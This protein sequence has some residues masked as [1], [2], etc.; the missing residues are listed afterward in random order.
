MS[1]EQAID[2]TRGLCGAPDVPNNTPRSVVEKNPAHCR[3]CG[4][5]MYIEECKSLGMQQLDMYVL[6]CPNC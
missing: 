4:S 6:I 2:H 5:E 3:C 1:A